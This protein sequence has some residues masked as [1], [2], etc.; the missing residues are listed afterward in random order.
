MRPPAWLTL[1]RLANWLTFGVVVIAFILSFGALRDLAADV[2]I[3]YP[4]LYPVMIDAGLVI[5]NIMALQSSLNGERNRYAWALII[6]ATAAS[7]CLNVVHSLTALPTWLAAGLGSAMAAIPPLV[8]FGAFHLVVLRIEQHARHQRLV[9]TAAALE[10]AVAAR[11]AEQ[12]QLSA[13]VR[14]L[15]SEQEALNETIQLRTE[16]R[17]DLTIQVERL[18]SELNTLKQHQQTLTRTPVAPAV[19]AKTKANKA[20]AT[21]DIP[22]KETAME[23]LLTYVA[24]RP[25]ATLADIGQ[26]ISRSKSTVSHYVS[27]LL[28]AERLSKNG[29][30]WEVTHE[31]SAETELQDHSHLTA[32]PGS[33][34]TH[35][36]PDKEVN[37]PS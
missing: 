14:T 32:E 33:T 22:D 15:A 28:Q 10:T 9:Q 18:V 25:E 30:G 21:T 12:Q 35:A 2:G 11:A 5:Y 23:T 16:E 6:L 34:A 17:D 31:D 37:T 27:E 36:E 24:Q 20:K 1:D 19:N 29:R 8:I 26:A 3:V 7:V 13:A 4:A